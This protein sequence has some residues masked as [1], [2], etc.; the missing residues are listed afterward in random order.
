STY[1]TGTLTVADS[2]VLFT[3]T[4]RHTSCLSHS[5]SDVSSSALNTTGALT[6]GN[7]G[8]AI[9]TTFSGG[10]TGTNNLT[11]NSNATTGTITLSTRS[12][13]RRGGKECRSRRTR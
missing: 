7:T 3:S 8:T 11:I 13:E 4:S 5:S 12:E 2:A 9:S 6:L 10:V 1:G